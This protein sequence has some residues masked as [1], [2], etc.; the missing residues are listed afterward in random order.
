MLHLAAGMLL[1]LVLTFEHRKRPWLV[2]GHQETAS[3]SGE[4]HHHLTSTSLLERPSGKL[5]YPRGGT[6]A[7]R[8]YLSVATA[9][10][11][12]GLVSSI[13]AGALSHSPQPALMYLVPC[14]LAPVMA[15]AHTQ[16]ELRELWGGERRTEASGDHEKE[17]TV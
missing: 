7:C 12:A 17:A 3:R 13:A 10:Y 11:A 15:K 16:G 1:A 5:A 6:R 4:D 8:S 14:I 2:A 9:G